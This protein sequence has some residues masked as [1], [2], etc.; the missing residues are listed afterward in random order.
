MGS[1]HLRGVSGGHPGDRANDYSSR[2]SLGGGRFL[3][4]D[5]DFSHIYVQGYSPS[6]DE[7]RSASVVREFERKAISRCC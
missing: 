3:C 1:I 2:L 5:R 7:D 4:T 6:K